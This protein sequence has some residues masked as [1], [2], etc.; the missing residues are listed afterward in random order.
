VADDDDST[1][2]GPKDRFGRPL[3]HAK[4]M[5]KLP[6][7]NFPFG[8]D[9]SDPPMPKD[10]GEV[11]GK[12]YKFTAETNPEG[13]VESYSAQDPDASLSGQ[14]MQGPTE[15]GQP[16]NQMDRQLDLLLGGKENASDL[17]PKEY[18]ALTKE[19][20]RGN[21]LA[22]QILVKGHFKG[23]DYPSLTQDLNKIEDPFVKAL[24]NMPGV[25]N[26]AESQVVAATQPYNFTNAES[27]VNNILTNQGYAANAQPSAETSAFVNKIDAEAAG[28][29]LTQS[30]LGLPSI[31]QALAG[32]GPAA[33]LSEKAAPT[34]ALVQALLSHLQYEDV[35]G[36]GL[37]SSAGQPNWLQQLLAAVTG[38]TSTGGLVSPATAAAG[39]GA[40]P[41]ETST[42][43]G[44][45]A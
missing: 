34:S 8:D 39:I 9:D 19:A 36:T 40:V 20:S 45:N 30:A 38:T 6:K 18:D 15:G 3:A 37:S 23:K 41:T 4:Q 12:K 11:G 31:S 26:T 17:S 13:E 24:S 44:S 32:L 28:N 29:P 7:T 5:D 25:A 14:M 21:K 42:P 10:E 35:Y 2:V 1:Q 22:Q 43:T 33:K 16:K 27:Q